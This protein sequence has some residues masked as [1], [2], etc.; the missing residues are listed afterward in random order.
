MATNCTTATAGSTRWVFGVTAIIAVGFL[1]WGFVST[2]TL[3]SASGTA[4]TWVMDNVG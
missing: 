1:V 3:A 2:K 4:L